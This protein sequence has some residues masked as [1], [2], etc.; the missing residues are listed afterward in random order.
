MLRWVLAVFV[1]TASALA[2]DLPRIRLLPFLTGFQRPL[3]CIDDRSGRI[4]VVEQPGRIRVS[5]D[6]MLEPAP[7]L[8]I[9]DRVYSGDNECGLLGLAFHPQFKTNGRFFVNYTTKKRG[10]LQTRVSEFKVDP[11]A[12]RAD[13]GSERELLTFDQPFAN[14]NG[15]CV[16]FGPDGMLYIGTGDGGAANDPQENGQNLGTWLAKILRID[17][18]HK[19][20]YA[21][22]ADNPFVG[23]EKAL[24]EI[25]AYGLRNPWR[26]SFDRETG[27][28]WCGDVGQN[29][30]EEVDIIERGK[31]YGWS[32]KEGLHDFE[33][34][35][36]V[37]PLTDPIKEYGRELGQSITGGYVYRGK[38]FPELQG[39]YL[40]ADY[41]SSRIFALK[42]DGHSLTLD[43]QILQPP[44]HISSFGED[45]DGELYVCDH[46]G[47]RLFRVAQ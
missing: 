25:W 39:I 41:Q 31:N 4:F 44:F 20:P 30:W 11:T 40:Y 28:L 46:S 7:F 19:Q 2:A 42:W 27:Q 16:I 17:V 5:H 36:A 9:T 45:K 23:K 26:F 22:P 29:K 12:L 15:G 8:D 14:H 47:G 35:R 34:K 33:P 43:G 13:S 38:Q 10:K 32:A 24:P 6:G 21:V 18:D 1:L 37:G 3:A